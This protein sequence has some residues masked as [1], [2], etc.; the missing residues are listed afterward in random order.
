MK[1]ITTVLAMI[2]GYTISIQAQSLD[3]QYEKMIVQY[4]KALES[5]DAAS[6]ASMYT[7]DAKFTDEN[8]YT[9]AAMIEKYY[10]EAFKK[11]TYTSMDITLDE[12]FSVGKDMAVGIGSYTGDLVVEPKK[13]KIKITGYYQNVIKKVNGKWKIYRHLSAKNPLTPTM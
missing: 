5:K 12:V 7:N 11:A 1:T 2:L 13:D 3:S 4:E 8:T 6:I 9:G 10:T